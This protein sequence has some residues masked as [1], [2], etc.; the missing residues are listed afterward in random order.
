MNGETLTPENVI[1]SSPVIIMGG[2]TEGGYSVNF[3]TGNISRLGY[4]VAEIVME[5]IPFE[6]IVHPGDKERM[7]KEYKEA[8]ARGGDTA[9]FQYK[10]R[11]R[12]GEVRWIEENTVF[13]KDTSGRIFAYQSTLTDVT[14]EKTA[15][16]DAEALEARLKLLLKT[17]GASVWEYEA[18][19]DSFSGED[20]GPIFGVEEG[21]WQ[22]SRQEFFDVYLAAPENEPAKEAWRRLVSGETSSLD[23][24]CF[25]C[26]PGGKKL[27]IAFRGAAVRDDHGQLT[28]V[29]G[30][31]SDITELKRAEI[32]AETRNR[33]LALINGSS[34]AF[35]EEL[36]PKALLE[37]ILVK[38]CELAGTEHGI[39]SVNQEEKGE[40]FWFL[41]TGLYAPL[42]GKTGKNTIGAFSEVLRFKRRIVIRDYQNYENRLRDSIFKDVE[43]VI[44]IPFYYGKDLKGIMAVAFTHSDPPFD[45]DLP[46][47]L[48]IL[49]ASAAAALKNAELYEESITKL[50][51]R[52]K[53]QED[54][55]FH[56]R[57]VRAVAEGS[58]FLVS[59]DNQQQALEFALRGLGEAAGVLGASLYRLSPDREGRTV[60]GA[61]AR[62]ARPGT[63]RGHSVELSLIPLDGSLTGAVADIRSGRIIKGHLG[64]VAK[65]AGVAMPAGAPLWF[66]A[67]PVFFNSVFWGFLA[68]SFDDEGLAERVMK[69][70]VLRT[71]AHNMAA[72]VMRWESEREALTAYEKLTGTFGDAIRTLGQIVGRKDPYTTLHQERV[73]LLALKTGVAMGLSDRRLEGLRI[74][75]LVHDVG[76]VEIPSEI[77]SKPGRLSELEFDLIKTHA[78]SGYQI[79]KEIDFPWPVAEI[80]RQHHERLDG[81]GYPHGLRGEEIMTEARI[82]AVTDVVEAMASHRPYRPSLGLDAA[83]AEIKK[84]SGIYY[85]PQAVEACLKVI[86]EDP[87]ILS[88]R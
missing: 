47:S 2:D 1:A 66:V 30:I 46:D 57:L 24:E 68:L 45:D 50:D 79:L 84:F 44:A 65:A 63:D 53:V 27:W 3:I 52:K 9:L 22:V 4:S 8:V 42:I 54:L 40:F 82:L 72:S 41:G 20:F 10:V 13:Q 35:F 15:L 85:D 58:G 62:Y 86:T 7:K 55:R 73:S 28:S 33:R 25:V 49:A 5:E 87:G 21:G 43:T 61:H 37:R 39:L 77:L 60:A 36:D 14:D 31:T 38:A 56:G 75:G 71:A 81:S 11:T 12:D 64:E 16:L 17:A 34:A 74:A 80:A 23:V 51:E 18:A 32:E 76:K 88:P 6:T 78:E 26:L 59:L 19:S 70:D 29:A 69:E 67:A 48:E 83:A